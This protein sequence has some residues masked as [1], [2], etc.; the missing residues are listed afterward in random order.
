VTTTT[1]DRLADVSMAVVWATVILLVLLAAPAKSAAS[2]DRPGRSTEH[3]YR[4]RA[5]ELDL[6]LQV[7]PPLVTFHRVN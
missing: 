1:W 4:L 7:S 5:D 6:Q 2:D 3:F